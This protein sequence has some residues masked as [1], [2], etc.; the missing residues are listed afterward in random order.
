MEQPRSS[1]QFTKVT[2]TTTTTTTTTTK[3]KKRFHRYLFK[4]A[5]LQQFQMSATISIHLGQRSATELTMEGHKF[6]S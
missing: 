6:L 5:V 4:I 1:T 3:K 2:L